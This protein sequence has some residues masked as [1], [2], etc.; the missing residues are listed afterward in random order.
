MNDNL[1]VLLVCTGDDTYH[2]HGAIGSFLNE[3]L[4]A[5]GFETTYTT[6][7]DVFTPENLHRYDTVVM[8]AVQTRAPVERI[9]AL[10]KAVGGAR[11]NDRGRPVGFV[12]VHGVTTSFQDND[13]FRNM[14]GAAFVT[15]P[16]MG[17]AYRFIVQDP[18]HPVMREINDFNLVDELYFF[19]IRARFPVLL[20]CFYEGEE[21]PVAWCRPYGEGRVFYLALGHGTEQLGNENVRR[22]IENGV[23]WTAGA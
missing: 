4:G 16:D 21:R 8:Y 14:I 17:P 18:S 19:D 3:M 1:R 9:D 20:S 7:F 15:H 22:M 12:G 6:D 5:S 13:G 11:L 2:D 10:L 23:R